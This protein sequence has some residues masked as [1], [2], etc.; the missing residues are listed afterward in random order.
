MA[1][2]MTN[3]DDR[4]PDHVAQR[5]ARAGGV[6]DPPMMRVKIDRE[7]AHPPMIASTSEPPAGNRSEV[8][9]SIVGQKYQVPMA[10]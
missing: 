4:Q 8:M 3:E 9:P 7:R 1:A 10:R 6:I 5:Q 2:K